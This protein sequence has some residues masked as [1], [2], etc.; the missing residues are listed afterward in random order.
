[1]NPSWH[2]KIETSFPGNWLPQS[3]FFTSN[4]ADLTLWQCAAKS[5]LSKNCPSNPNL[6][7]G[8]IVWKA[9]IWYL[10]QYP[11]RP[12][13]IHRTTSPT[14]YHPQKC[15]IWTR[16]GSSTDLLLF[17]QSWLCVHFEIWIWNK[18]ERSTLWASICPALSNVGEN[19]KL[20]S[21]KVHLGS[22]QNHICTSSRSN[23]PENTIPAS[24]GI[25]ESEYEW[26]FSS[27][28]I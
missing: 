5:R 8:N 2:W 27:N 3:H 25:Q 6:K 21:C 7:F 23:H 4:R 26:N 28:L 22:D 10:K 12:N 13:F 11:I 20:R 19:E 18:I 16:F 17:S 15:W 14:L 24:L 9:Q 1:M